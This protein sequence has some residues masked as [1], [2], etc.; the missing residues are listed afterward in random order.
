[1]REIFDNWTAMPIKENNE[2]NKAGKVYKKWYF[3]TLSFEQFV[4]LGNAF[5]KLDVINGKRKKVLPIQVKDWISD[6]SLAYWLMDDGSNKWKNKVLALRFCTDCFT[7]S[8]NNM[9]ISILK[10]KF[11][12]NVTK[13]KNKDNKWKLYVGTENYE[14]IKKLIYPHLIPSMSYKF[15]I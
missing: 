11:D 2:K 13:T 7:E 10:D 1:M 15:P 8:E 4:E 12:L 6:L 14:K 5:Y 9:L 3:N